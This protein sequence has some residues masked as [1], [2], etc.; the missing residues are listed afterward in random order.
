MSPSCLL[1]VTVTCSHITSIMARRGYGPHF[2]VQTS[3]L[4]I[5]ALLKL[6][7]TTDIPP[8][9]QT[10]REALFYSMRT[11]SII[12]NVTSIELVKNELECAFMCLRNY[13]RSCLSF[14]FGG[15]LSNEMRICEL[16][17]SERALEPHR[18]QSRI[19]FDYF[20]VEKVVSKHYVKA[21][22][23]CFFFFFLAS[24]IYCIIG[25]LQNWVNILLCELMFSWKQVLIG[26]FI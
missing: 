25:Y 18:M 20:G 22:I 2:K 21:L 3:V 8:E 6:I 17:N 24:V 5:F 15:N 4:V 12:G 14:N 1:L 11:T 10:H 7:F 26:R 13:P 16:S 19:G 9:D 23:L